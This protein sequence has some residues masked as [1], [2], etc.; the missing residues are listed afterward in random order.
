MMF[1]CRRY[2]RLYSESTDR[3]L[4][5]R[6][7]TF[8]DSHVARCSKCADSSEEVSLAL[9]MLRG[10]AME[11]QCC[12]Q[13]DE[14]VAR[15]VRLQKAR[16]EFRYWSPMFL[17]AAVTAVVVLAAVQML[18]QSASLPVFKSNPRFAP[19]V[20]R[21]VSPEVLPELRYGRNMYQK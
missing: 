11:P 16:S 9:N 18:T 6:E 3:I 4:T 1:G 2:R 21:T 7:K 5:T 10:A 15:L 20:K 19:E 12:Q 13:F 17:S 8:L 14:R